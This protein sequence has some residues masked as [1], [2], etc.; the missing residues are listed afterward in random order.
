MGENGCVIGCLTKPGRVKIG[1]MVRG[2]WG[3][4]KRNTLKEHFRQLVNKGQLVLQGKG[5]GAW[6]V[7]R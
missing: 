1:D 5:R 6:Y 7:L 2:H 3:E 4:P